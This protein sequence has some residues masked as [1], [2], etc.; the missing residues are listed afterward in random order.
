MY[1]V[2]IMFILPTHASTYYCLHNI[3]SL[4]CM[5][6][7]RKILTQQATHCQFVNNYMVH[8]FGIYVC[9]YWSSRSG[10]KSSQ[11]L[12]LRLM[13]WMI[14]C[15]ITQVTL[16]KSSNRTPYPC[17][18]SWTMPPSDCKDVLL[19]CSTGIT[20]IRSLV[21]PQSLHLRMESKSVEANGQKIKQRKEMK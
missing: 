4:H 14:R 7:T 2:Y 1:Y 17:I 21:V 13:M 16:K 20:N 15:P 10:M 19:T 5:L 9:C 3:K 6:L 12:L 8:D 18:C 11:V